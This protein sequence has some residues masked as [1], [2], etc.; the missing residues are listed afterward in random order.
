MFPHLW[1]SDRSV[2]I[3]GR[4]TTLERNWVSTARDRDGRATMFCGRATKRP[5]ADAVFHFLA[6]SRWE[7]G[8]RGHRFQ[9]SSESRFTVAQSEPAC[10]LT[11]ELL[12]LLIRGNP[13]RSVATRVPSFL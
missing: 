13:T 5:C 8:I 11:I 10:S 4:E 7:L 2:F 1:S 9:W 3:R 6:T 12:W